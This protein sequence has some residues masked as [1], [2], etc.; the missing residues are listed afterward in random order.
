MENQ[1]VGGPQ[2]LFQIA[3]VPIRSSSRC[4]RL[5]DPYDYSLLY[6]GNKISGERVVQVDDPDVVKVNYGIWD[7]F[8]GPLFT[9]G[10]TPEFVGTHGILLYCQDPRNTEGLYLGAIAVPRKFF[11]TG[12]AQRL[13]CRLE[14]IAIA[15]GKTH[16]RL[17]TR[18]YM[19]GYSLFRKLGYY[20]SDD[21]FS[22]DTT[23]TLV[24][25]KKRLKF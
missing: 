10:G 14:R 12:I 5:K 20:V 22:Y 7:G 6:A 21:Y 9:I 15:T 16:I 24:E 8:F 3:E 1:R 11:G 23:G 2:G 25:M 18:D 13:V 17:Q 4:V 19:P